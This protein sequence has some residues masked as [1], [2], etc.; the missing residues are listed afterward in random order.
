MN[1][2]LKRF[3]FLAYALDLLQEAVI[4][5]DV[6]LTIEQFEKLDELL[7]VYLE[8]MDVDEL[9]EELIEIVKELTKDAE[10][11]Q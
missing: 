5:E 8:Q 3:M 4:I 1:T 9:K 11:D 7:A 10:P 2:A 6:G